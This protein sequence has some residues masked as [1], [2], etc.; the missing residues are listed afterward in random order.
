[1]M[2]RIAVAIGIINEAAKAMAAVGITAVLWPLVGFV[3][4][5]INIIWFLIICLFLAALTKYDP[6]TM[7]VSYRGSGSSLVGSIVNGT[8]TQVANNA[9]ATSTFSNYL[10]IN[11]QTLMI[12]WAINIFGFLWTHAFTRYIHYMTLS[13]AFANWYFAT[14][15]HTINGK[16]VIKSFG[17]TLRYHLGSIAFGSLIL[18]IVQMIRLAFNYMMKKLEK[19]KDNPVIKFLWCCV[20]CCLKCLE[21]FI[22]FLNKNSFIM[23]A[24]HGWGFCKAAKEAFLLLLRNALRVAAVNVLGDFLLFLG[25]LVVTAGC[26]MLAFGYFKVCETPATATTATCKVLGSD[27][28]VT[29]SV[30]TVVVCG[31]LGY[32][33]GKLFMGVFEVGIDTIF[34][35]FCHDI[36]ANDGSKEKPYFMTKGLRDVVGV[37]NKKITPGAD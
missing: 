33:I 9:S 26:V 4:S 7:Q 36:D 16:T 35:C 10:S 14:D 27:T 5:L 29:L 23:I 3:Q 8:I 24:I 1:M 34:L 21:R 30:G 25:N 28:Q 11:D 37:K 17:R 31:V 32:I 2:K 22:D 6:L 13:G 20:N 12:V 19:G 18:T 15:K